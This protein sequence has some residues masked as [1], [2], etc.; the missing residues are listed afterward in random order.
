MKTALLFDIDGTLVDTSAGMA[1]VLR[2]VVEE[3]GRAVDEELLR[4]VVSRPLTTSLGALL[5]LPAGHVEVALAADRARQ[6]FTDRVIP[7]ATELVFPGVPELLATL[8]AAGHPLAVVTSKI[9]RSAVELLTATGL[10]DAFDTLSCHDMA[11]RGKPHPDLALLAAEALAV[12]PRCCVVI[13][14]TVDDVRMAQA[15]GMTA[16]GVRTGV[17]TGDALATAG[18]RVVLPGPAALTDVPW[19]RDGTT[20]DLPLSVPLA[21]SWE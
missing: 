4:R 20:D 3:H 15:A 5:D 12:P 10:L 17:A 14:D 7:A 19:L 21:S 1:R 11:S 13:G 8:R 9:R 18:A 2:T 16:I 6:L